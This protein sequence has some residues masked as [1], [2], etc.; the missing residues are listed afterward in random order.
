MIIIES[1]LNYNWGKNTNTKRI[2]FKFQEKN[3]KAIEN[4]GLTIQIDSLE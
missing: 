4:M 2:S 1:N 3:Y